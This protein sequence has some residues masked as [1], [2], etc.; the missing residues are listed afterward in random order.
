MRTFKNVRWVLLG[1]AMMLAA[2]LFIAVRSSSILN[3]AGRGDASA[4]HELGVM[5]SN[6]D[7]VPQDNISAYMWFSLAQPKNGAS[8]GWLRLL[9]RS[10]TRAEIELAEEMARA[11]QQSNYKQCSEPRNIRADA[12]EQFELGVM[13]SN[14]DGVPVD[15]V[16]AY[17]WFTLAQPKIEA[18]ARWL[19]VVQRRMTQA[20]IELAE[21]MARACQQSNYKQCDKLGSALEASKSIPMK[22]QGGIYVVPV[23]INNAI[24]LDF[25]VDSGAAAVMLPADVVSTLRRQ[26]AIET[27]DFID[28]TTYALADGSTMPSAKFRIRSLK[29]GD[30]IVEGVIGGV[31]PMNGSLLL[32]QSFLGHFKSWSIN[33]SSHALTLE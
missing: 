1:I 3:R 27:R 16:S 30:K 33:N 23:L 25:A 11:C 12:S 8:A 4:Q 24:T 6:G 9:Q 17:M 5:Y 2:V 19:Q 14:G 28:N 7:G 31:A 10:M 15:N 18:S 32:G 21:E 26:G 29:V 20:E 22:S 13:Y